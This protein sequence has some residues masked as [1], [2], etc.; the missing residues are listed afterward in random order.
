MWIRFSRRSFQAL[1]LLWVTG[2]PLSFESVARAADAQPPPQGANGAEADRLFQ[3]ATERMDAGDFAAACPLFEQSQAAD[4]SSGTLLNLGDCYEHLGRSASAD[5]TFAKASELARRTGHA[6]R[7]EVAE[8][9]RHR[10]ASQLRH[11]RLVLPREPANTRVSVDGT[12][13]QRENA[14]LAVDPGR[15][16]LRATAPGYQDYVVEIAAPEPGAT[17]DVNIPVL[18]RPAG[19]VSPTPTSG[20]VHAHPRNARR[21]AA[22][23]S[24]AVGV[25]GIVTGSVFGLRSMSKHDESDKY[26]TGK[27]CPDQRGVDAMDSARA[28]GNVSTV[29]FIVGGVGLGAA[30]AL[31]F[32]HPAEEDAGVRVGVAAGTLQLRTTF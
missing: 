11:V 19:A 26:C 8:I 21:I 9:R 12:A 28:A 25:V 6:D 4:P 5:A 14:T 27:M 2:A 17:V 24:G 15:H 29:A 13:L 30:A 32:I 3:A 31:W 16:T 22:I 20:E 10:L 1:L 23:A 18:A 7:V